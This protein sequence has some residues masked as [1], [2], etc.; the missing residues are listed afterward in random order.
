MPW[1]E[2]LHAEGLKPQE[3]ADRLH[4]SVRTVYRRLQD[5]RAREPPP[6]Y[7]WPARNALVARVAHYMRE[8]RMSRL[9]AA[10]RVLEEATPSQI[11]TARPG[12]RPLTARRLAAWSKP[13]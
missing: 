4:I 10:R 6:E 13:K 9:A 2:D 8:E 1:I 3:I 7:F 11:M 12:V 5:M